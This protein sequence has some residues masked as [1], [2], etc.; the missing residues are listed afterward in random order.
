MNYIYVYIIIILLIGMFI[1]PV[2]EVV[3]KGCDIKQYKNIK[4]YQDGIK[5]FII[6][7][8]KIDNK[9]I[10][11]LSKY[12]LAIIEPRNITKNQVISLK[13]M[14]VEVLGYIS[15]VE[16]NENNIEFSSLKDSWFYKPNGKKIRIDKWQSW[17][18]DIRK[19][20]YQNF[21]LEQI[22]LHVIDKKLDGIFFDTVG[23]ID[24]SNW[25]QK[26]KNE[27]REA[28]QT[29]LFRIKNNYKNLK[30]IQNWG[31]ETAKK[32]LDNLDGIMWEGFSFELL[33]KDQWTK[34][35]FEE[36]KKTNL[37]FYVVSP[38]KEDINKN[39]IKSNL[40][41]YVRKNDIYD[42]LK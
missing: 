18:M 30:I 14:G 24:D 38:V 41:I 26:D 21:L 27:M 6:Y 39:P 17:Y 33:K 22:Y 10:K 1:I 9:K 2:Q 29:F 7:Y 31:F 35:R 20:D 19:K 32:C 36:I 23:D 8:G 42:T 34:N 13:K 11:D 4:Y 15:V 40:Y 12:S 16:Q 5:N 25:I 28:Y 3:S 37:D